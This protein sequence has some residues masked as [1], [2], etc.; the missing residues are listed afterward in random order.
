MDSQVLSVDVPDTLIELSIIT[1][2]VIIGKNWDFF[3]LAQKDFLFKT[4]FADLVY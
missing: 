4:N 3:T 1:H 2:R